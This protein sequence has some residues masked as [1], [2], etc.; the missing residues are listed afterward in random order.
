MHQTT[1]KPQQSDT[2]YLARD[3]QQTAMSRAGTATVPPPMTFDRSKLVVVSTVGLVEFCEPI[4]D[5]GIHRLYT[6][7]KTC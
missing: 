5:N 4:D 3:L 6:Q 2:D 7:R 1:N